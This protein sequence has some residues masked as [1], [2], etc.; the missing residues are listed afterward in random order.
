[1]R[2]ILSFAWR[3]TRSSRRRLALYSL[4]IVL[5]IA[6]LVS[7]GSF[8]ANVRQAIDAEAKG[9][10]GADLFVT[11]PAPLTAPVL[12]YLRGLGGTMARE[13]TFSSM[14]TFPAT[15]RL[16]LVQVHAVE[17]DFPFYGSFETDPAGGLSLLQGPG[18]PRVILEPTLMDQFRVKVGDP[19][20]LGR[21]TFT[22][23]GAVRKVPGESPG[24]AMMAPRA[25]IPLAALPDTGLASAAAAPG[26][27]CRRGRPR[28][29]GAL[30]LGPPV[31]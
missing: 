24:V 14:L 15:K 26:P 12:E 30:R 27:N 31:L 5:G 10:L 4:S 6:A 11:S 17:G 18:G 8:S 7:I 2:F 28:H 9:L 20:R 16:R 23:A 21:T 22:V 1:M 3:D 19:V 13:Q 25:Y 29:E